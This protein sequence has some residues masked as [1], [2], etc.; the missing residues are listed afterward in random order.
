MGRLAR[1][2]GTAARNG[3]ARTLAPFSH[4]SAACQV[5]LRG[6][7]QCSHP[8]PSSRIRVRRHGIQATHLRRPC[9]PLLGEVA[10]SLHRQPSTRSADPSGL[11]S[12]EA[13]VESALDGDHEADEAVAEVL[14]EAVNNA[15][16]HGRAGHVDITIRVEE[17]TGTALRP[18]L[19][20]LVLDDGEGAATPARRGQGSEL[21]DELCRFWSLD[22][23]T[24]GATFRAVVPLSAAVLKASS[25][26][27]PQPQA[28]PQEEGHSRSPA[29]QLPD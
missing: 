24:G 6:F 3:A 16:R 23:G 19:S 1:E 29:E 28:E 26:I 20:I 7:R 17:A 22:W 8:A 2:P 4:D 18:S 13:G 15:I 12:V 10:N 21:F 27:G 14:K 11:V 9:G 25:P 5:S